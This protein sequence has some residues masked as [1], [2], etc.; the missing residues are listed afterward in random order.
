MGLAF[1]IVNFV[2]VLFAG[3]FG[4]LLLTAVV[5]FFID[6]TQRADAI[7]RNY[8]V[9]GRFRYLFSGLGEFFRQYFFAMDREE[10]PFNRAQRDWV[11]H[12]AK[13]VDNMVAFGSTRNT[14]V[15]GTPIFVN[16]AFP[17]LDDQFAKTAPMVIGEGV[18]RPFT[19]PSIFNISGMSYGAISK[20]AVRALSRG[21]KAAG[22]WLNTGEGGLSPF[23][24]EGGC[25]VVFQ[26]GTANFGV[27][28]PDGRLSDDKLREMAAHETVRMFEIKMSQGAKPGKGGILPGAKVTPEIAAI[29]GLEVG[30]DGISPN[31]HTGVDDWGDMLNLID[32]VRRVTGKPV[33][34]KMVVGSEEGIAG[35]FEEIG[36]RGSDSA[37]DFLT[38]DGGEGGTGAAPMPLM[39][40]VGMSVRESLP[41]VADMRNA[42]GL[43]DRIRLIAGAK[44]VNPGDV[45]WA[46]AAGADFVV[47]AR[48]FMFALGC[49]QA[50]KCNK[51]TCPTGITT[52]DPRFQKGLVVEDKE[53]RVA[54]YAS[55]IIKEVEIIAH[56]VGVAEPRL[57]RRLHVRMMQDNGRSV[58]MRDVVGP[59]K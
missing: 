26:I 17:P 22:I 11:D 49:I 13:G 18:P 24:L 6:R 38:I 44:M 30:Q 12:A 41:L 7:R 59:S 37:P 27:R 29:R 4:L 56:S 54:R 57:I 32:R 28:G 51:N 52:H 8:P 1:Q 46:L 19:A 58:S 9:I 42:A 25:D 33:G 16:S 43:K 40:L 10:L 53:V 2:A 48:G 15:P 47:S 3:L 35:L 36:R 21:A 23:H 31:R 34:L 39:D 50:L 55:Q 20:P 5:M 14:D 45:A